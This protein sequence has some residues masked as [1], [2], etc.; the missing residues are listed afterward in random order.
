MGSHFMFQYMYTLYNVYI[1][2]NFSNVY[3][4]FHGENFQNPS[5]FWNVQYITPICSHPAVLEHQDFLLLL[6]LSL[7]TH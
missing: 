4:F 1:R 2:L 3:P 5:S 6:C 7:S